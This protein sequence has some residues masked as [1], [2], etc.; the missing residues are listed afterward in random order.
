MKVKLKRF[1][2]SAIFGGVFISISLD[3]SASTLHAI[4]PLA[5]GVQYNYQ[6]TPDASRVIYSKQ[7]SHLDPIELYSVPLEGDRLPQKISGSDVVGSGVYSNQEIISSD[8]EQLVYIANNSAD[9]LPALN[10][11]STLIDGSGLPVSISNLYQD[12]NL[13][14]ITPDDSRVVFSAGDYQQWSLYSTL[15]DGSAGEPIALST[16]ALMGN[17]T[18][19]IA[20][21]DSNKVVYLTTQGVFISS[22][23]SQI[24]STVQ[25]SNTNYGYAKIELTSDQQSILISSY[26]GIYKIPLDGSTAPVAL[27]TG[28]LT[29]YQ[30]LPTGDNIIV[31]GRLD[32]TETA[33][34]YSIHLDES[35]PPVALHEI[36]YLGIINEDTHVKASSNG[37]WIVYLAD[38]E[39]NGKYDLYKAP[40]DGSQAAVKLNEGTVFGY[41]NNVDITPDGNW[42]IYT[43][44]HYGSYIDDL[45]KVSLEN[46]QAPVKLNTPDVSFNYY[47]PFLI[48]QDSKRVFISG[49]NN[50]LGDNLLNF[51]S[52]RIDGVIAPVSLTNEYSF[53]HPLTISSDL[54]YLILPVH[55]TS[56]AGGSSPLD[57]YTID[58]LSD[59]DNDQI[60]D[61]D[62]SLP[63]GETDFDGDGIADIID[64]DD[65]NDGV[66]DIED[67]FPLNASETTDTDND[68][69]GNNADTDDDNDGVSDDLDAFPL[70]AS[71]SIDTD[72]DG[73]GNNADTDDDQ[74]G[75]L[76]VDDAFPLDTS[77]TT[78]T[79]NDGIGNNADTDDDND[80]VS[81]D[82]DAFPLDASESIDTDN[83][84]IG[85]NADTDDDQDGALDLDDAFPLDTSESKD[86]DSDGIGNN[87]DTDDD[88]DG[89]LDNDEIS[90]GSDPLSDASKALDT[91]SDSQP[92]CIDHDDDNDSVNDTIDNCPLII[93]LDQNDNDADGQGDLCDEDDDNDGYLDLSDQCPLSNNAPKLIVNSCNT[94]VANRQV[95]NGC[96]IVDSFALCEDSSQGF[97]NCANSLVSQF[98]SSNIINR[99]E[100]NAIKK[101]LR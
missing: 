65:D 62:D 85:N 80:G 40:T 39:L 66:L 55:N 33:K 98:S 93:N 5:V 27:F 75:V 37:N 59:A 60:L 7:V 18:G 3:L 79:D 48:S 1:I 78:D 35:I 21:P 52:V 8:S 25:L 100:K 89:Q 74:D 54:K 69:I 32:N 57:L 58:L 94:N 19:F 83:D 73:I 76:D 43:E 90:C 77:E 15:L 92:D 99:K 9:Q 30:L 72:N 49:W 2:S 67:A 87:A 6:L 71:E 53:T 96:N 70:D 44:T 46:S 68:G 41:I 16:Y 22:T 26:D 88:N 38:P 47:P 13:F 84:G 97:T 86:T 36:N 51:Y 63:N 29:F 17:V 4:K 20:I 95:E 50:A 23:D 34:L 45:K 81:D 64:N 31:L 82:L 61:I 91:D 11:V 101:C 28:N 56:T 42:V 14:Q 10:L 12:I 24:T